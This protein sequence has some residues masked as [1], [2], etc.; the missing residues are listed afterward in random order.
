MSAP[1]AAQMQRQNFSLF[2]FSVLALLTIFL[3]SFEVRSQ[4][5]AKLTQTIFSSLALVINNQTNGEKSSGTA[6]C[7]YSTKFK[8]YFITNRHVIENSKEI[9]VRPWVLLPGVLVPD[10]VKARTYPRP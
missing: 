3:W 8:S 5:N 2:G 7:V 4:D 9:L 10:F 1:C 6:F